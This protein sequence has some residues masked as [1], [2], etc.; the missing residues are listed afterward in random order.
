MHSKPDRNFSKRLFESLLNSLEKAT[1][2]GNTT[3]QF[4]AVGIYPFNPQAVTEHAFAI[5]DVSL[6]DTTFAFISDA[7]SNT[8]TIAIVSTYISY[9]PTAS[10]DSSSRAYGSGLSALSNSCIHNLKKGVSSLQYNHPF[11]SSQKS[12]TIWTKETNR[13]CLN[14]IRE[15]KNYAG[16]VGENREKVK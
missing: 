16:K 6:N 10:V 5:S 9:G 15:K 2:V 13:R 7:C 8:H 1:T 3:F 14:C 11:S 12:K 4:L